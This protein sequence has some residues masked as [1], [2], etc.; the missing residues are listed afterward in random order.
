MNPHVKY[1]PDLSDGSGRTVRKPSSGFLNTLRFIPIL[2]VL[3]IGFSLGMTTYSSSGN[4]FRNA[5]DSEGGT[6]R[7]QLQSAYSHIL[8]GD[9]N[10]A[11]AMAAAVV[12]S[13]PANPLARHILGLAH[14]RR[15]LVEEAVR[16][17]Q[18]AVELNPRFDAA[19]FDLGIMEESRGEFSSALDAFSHALEL[20]P[21]NNRYRNSR[22]K[23]QEIITGE[24]DWDFNYSTSERLFLEGV[25]AVNR[26]SESDLQYAESIFRSIIDSRPYDVVSRNMLGMT[27]AKQGNLSSAESVLTGVIE[28]E[29]GYSDAWFNRGMVHRAMGLLESALSDFE[30]AKATS[31]LDTFR[32]NVDREIGQVRGLISNETTLSPGS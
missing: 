9:Y 26:G 7:G 19:W 21:D 27:L 13:D 30:S 12:R 16:E 32:A 1:S 22:D 24:N 28:D 15:G 2:L 25:N 14:A 17:F 8:S 29:P 3:I 4:S 11:A 31:S 18:A 6:Y 5:L 10:G 20:D 23:M